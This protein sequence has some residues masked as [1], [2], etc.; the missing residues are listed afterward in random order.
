MRIRFYGDSLTAGRPGVAF[1]PALEAMLPEDQ[2]INDGKGGETVL[3]LYRRIARDA[4]CDPVEIAVVWVGVNDVLA[5]VT[6]SHSVL[7]RL[8]RQPRARDHTRFRDTY[9][10]ILELLDKRATSVLAV[11]PLLIV[12]DL[13]NPWNKEL[14]N[15]CEIIASV[16]ASFDSVQS[17]DLRARV[18]EQLK[19][20]QASGYLPVSVTS[21]ACEA[22]FLRTPAH[23]DR[24][25]RRRGLRFTLDGVHLNSVGAAAVAQELRRALR[26]L[27]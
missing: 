21:I 8:M 1:F 11:S 5:R 14:A 15:L 16:C 25:A 4:A 2:L 13:E 10:R 6:G 27:A 23:V 17:L 12:E 22:L 26:R 18:A 20:K 9:R 7:K 3:S 24:V 19:G